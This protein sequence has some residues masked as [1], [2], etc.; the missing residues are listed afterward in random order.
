[1]T[2]G[3]RNDSETLTRPTLV[4]L[5][6]GCAVGFVVAGAVCIGIGWLNRTPN[7]PLADDFSSLTSVLWRSTFVV[8]GAALLVAVFLTLARVFRDSVPVKK[9]AAFTAPVLVVIVVATGN[10]HSSDGAQKAFTSAD[11]AQVAIHPFAV[12][13]VAHA[14][15]WLGC[16]AVGVLALTCF[17]DYAEARAEI[18]P[19][20]PVRWVAV[21]VAAV[22]ALV[23]VLPVMFVAKKS[24]FKGQTAGRIEVPALTDIHG[25]VAYRT[26]MRAAATDARPAGAGWVSVAGSGDEDNAIEGFDGATGQRRWWFSMRQLKVDGIASSGT[27]PESV[28]L[29]KTYRP[30]A[31]LLALDGMTG[32]LLWARAER[33]AFD[34]RI[35]P[36]ADVVLLQSEGPA[37]GSRWRALSVRTGNELWSK[38]FRN[39]C[40]EK[41]VPTTSAVVMRTCDGAPGVIAQVLDPQTGESVRTLTEDSLGVTERLTPDAGNGDHVLMSGPNSGVVVDVRSGHVVARLPGGDSAAFIDSESVLLTGALQGDGV[42][43]PVSILDLRDGHVI[44]TGLFDKWRSEKPGWQAVTRVGDQWVTLLPD[45]KWTAQ[46]R[47]VAGPPEMRVISRSGQSRTLPNPCGSYD[48]DPLV[49]S[50]PGAVLVACGVNP[51]EAVGVR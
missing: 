14:A 8:V 26:N 42:A 22:V 9:F 24:P 29:V 23:A 36:T 46:P 40:I 30:T 28:V 3:E 25:E 43:K 27:G 2:S 1:M 6:A 38:V 16:L 35:P 5:L 45:E 39:D 33:G 48:T 19:P 31:S 32:A 7:M 21:G 12:T 15:W 17:I 44:D 47:S 13:T 41:L 10:A 34:E 51:G 4:P 20:E 50:V 18:T 49:S 11:A 37:D